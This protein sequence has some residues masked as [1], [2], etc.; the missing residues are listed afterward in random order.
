M[1]AALLYGPQQV[2]LEEIPLPTVGD[3]D[4]LIRIAA[5]TTCGTDLKVFL[6]G[7]H[8]R[9]ITLPAVFGHEFSG[10][11]AAVR[12]LGSIGIDVGVVSSGRLCAAAWSRCARRSY[13]APPESE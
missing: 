10:T 3:G 13:S 12:H 4:V 2:V 11:I 6:Q 7:G 9:M 1:L 8:A 5:A